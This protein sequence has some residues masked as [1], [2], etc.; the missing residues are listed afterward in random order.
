MFNNS[1]FNN[2]LSKDSPLV[3]GLRHYPY[4]LGLLGICVVLFVLQVLTGV[5]ASSPTVQDLLKWGA[6]FLPL[7]MGNE[8]FRLITSLVLHIGLLHLMF[9]MYAL[10]YFGQVAE[11]MIGSIN[12]LILFVLSGIGGNLLN[13]FLALQTLLNNES[14]N[15]GQIGVSAGASGGIM[16]IGAA[17]LMTALLRTP[18]NQIGLN[19]RS[20]LLVMAINLSY[21]FL[22]SGIDNAGHIGGALTGAMLGFVYVFNVKLN[23]NS[24]IFV[25]F[26]PFML[27][28][29][30]LIVM[31]F[32]M[33]YWQLHQNTMTLIE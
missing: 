14:I 28:A 20:L 3:L 31:L 12:L 32:G 1:L 24:L 23:K 9:N 2:F 13:N 8:P 25:K 11:Q 30:M 29:F 16:G 7:T 26:S 33:M 15:R 19:F 22:V 18:I 10:Y 4:T 6:N 21:G 17:L 5:D 27:V